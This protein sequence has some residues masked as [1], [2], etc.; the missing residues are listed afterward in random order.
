[1][2]VI[3]FRNEDN[4]KIMSFFFVTTAKEYFLFKRA[5]RKAFSSFGR[6]FVKGFNVENLGIK[7][8][9]LKKENTYLVSP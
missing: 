5:A 8:G 3:V 1:M 9:F 4:Q 2:C 7:F 6:V